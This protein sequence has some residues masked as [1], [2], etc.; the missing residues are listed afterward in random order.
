MA[1]HGPYILCTVLLHAKPLIK[2]AGKTQSKNN[3]HTLII[4][5]RITLCSSS[6]AMISKHTEDL[7]AVLYGSLTVKKEH[8]SQVFRNKL[9]PK[10]KKKKKIQ[11]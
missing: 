9:L 10:K 5:L 1:Q 4:I 11:R 2:P 6:K 8:E 3:T 7:P